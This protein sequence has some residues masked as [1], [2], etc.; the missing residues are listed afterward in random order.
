MITS[1]IDGS[2]FQ[3]VGAA[4]ECARL[5]KLTFSL[6][7][8]ITLVV[9]RRRRPFSQAPTGPQ[10]GSVY[11]EYTYAKRFAEIDPKSKQ[12]SE[13]ARNLVAN[14]MKERILEIPSLDDALR[15]EVAVQYWGGHLGTSDQ[16]FR[17]NGGDW[18]AIPQPKGTPGPA[19]FY[20]RTVFGRPAVEVPLTRLK[21]GPNAFSFT[22]GRQIKY[23]YD[24]AHYWIYAF[25]ARVYLD[26]AKVEH[27]S[28]RVVEPAGGVLGENP[29]LSV[30][31][32]KAPAPIDHVDFIG[33]YRD[34]DRSGI[35]VKQQWHYGYDKGNMM[36]HIG[37]AKEGP[38]R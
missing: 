29:T 35:G 26:Q 31:I 23:E 30:E 38:G 6:T 2:I 11:R 14:A 20:Y 18:I 8:W 32:D 28:A 15:A 16:K 1:P 3:E 25:T 27:A 5:A 12:K 9:R 21:E 10:P 22:C 4:A 37:T 13:G 36:F 17:V 33:E 34:F 24:Y 19:M 7:S